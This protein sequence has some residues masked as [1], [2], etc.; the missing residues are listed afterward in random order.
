MGDAFCTEST[1]PH[2]EYNIW[3]RIVDADYGIYFYNPLTGASSWEPPKGAIV[4]LKSTD[5]AADPKRFMKS[6][7]ISAWREMQKAAGKGQVSSL[8]DINEP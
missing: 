4:E 3:R 6:F 2:A 5:A 1:T 8:R 7:D